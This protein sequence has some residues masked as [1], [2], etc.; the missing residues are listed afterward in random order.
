[1]VAGEFGGCRVPKAVVMSRVASSLAMSAASRVVTG[2]E[3]SA[4]WKNATRVVSF[5]S[6]TAS[7]AK[8]CTGT[9]VGD[10]WIGLVQLMPVN[11]RASN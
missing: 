11:R 5:G 1:V 2:G 10:G 3:P 4:A 6:C 9:A 7:A 8:R